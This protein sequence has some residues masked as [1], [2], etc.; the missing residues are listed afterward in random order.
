MELNNSIELL[1][2]TKQ[3]RNILAIF[4]LTQLLI[5]LILAIALLRED[6]QTII[7]PSIIS[8]EYLLTSNFLSSSY[9][10]DLAL[11]FI[12]LI[13][14]V[15]PS[16]VEENYKRFL[17]NVSAGAYPEVRGQLIAMMETINKKRLSTFFHVSEIASN[18]DFVKVKG[19]LTKVLGKTVVENKEKAFAIKFIRERGA[20][21]INLFEELDEI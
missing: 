14:N 12:Y 20:V 11:D 18:R 5:I 7:L 4:Q 16:N 17:N 2:K 6:K 19:R 13:L 15:N 21:K 1:N 8:E 9:R 3:Q 10:E